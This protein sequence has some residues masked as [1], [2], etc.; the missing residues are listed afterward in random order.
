[1]EE[2]KNDLGDISSELKD[3]LETELTLIKIEV[4]DHVSHHL[5]SILSRIFMCTLAFAAYLFLCVCAGMFLGQ[6]MALW[7]SFGLVALF[8]L[9]LVLLIYLFNDKMVQGPIQDFFIKTLAAK[10]NLG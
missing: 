4:I 10:F 2:L 8:S 5:A 7:M 6:F 1:M 9:V 3:H